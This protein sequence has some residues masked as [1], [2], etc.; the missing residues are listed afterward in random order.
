MG[1]DFSHTDAHWAYSGFNRFREALAKHEGFNLNEMAGFCAPPNRS[2]DEITTPLK[3]L[4]NH[5]DCEDELTPDE[6]RQVAPRLR[7]VI[8]A[9][10]TESDY[11]YQ[12][13]M[14][15]AEGMEC[16]ASNGEPLEF[17]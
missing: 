13:G 16:A 10:W 6:C 12:H 9:L 11:D 7:E 4:L 1:L 17:C 8:A 3:P 5:S 14:A 15:L 2:W